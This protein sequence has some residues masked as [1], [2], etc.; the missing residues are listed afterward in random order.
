MTTERVKI[1]TYITKEADKSGSYMER[2][3]LT[4]SKTC[5]LAIQLGIDAMA[6]SFDPD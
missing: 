3:G 1:T 2:M 4:K 5:S 6:I